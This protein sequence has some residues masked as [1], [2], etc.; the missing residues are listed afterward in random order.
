MIYQGIEYLIRGGLARNE[1]ALLIY[2]PDNANGKATV[3]TFKN[4]TREEAAASARRKIDHW[5]MQQKPKARDT[6]HRA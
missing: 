2:Y 4:G 6:G 1:W 3:G 5:L